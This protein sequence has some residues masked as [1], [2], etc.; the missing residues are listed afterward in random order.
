MLEISSSSS[1]FQ[2]C[3]HSLFQSYVYTYI[4]VDSWPLE[5]SSINPN[6][7][8]SLHAIKAKSIFQRVYITH[9]RYPYV[10]K[11]L[12][13]A[14]TLCLLRPRLH[15]AESETS[16]SL[17]HQLI[18][19]ILLLQFSSILSLSTS[20]FHARSHEKNLMSRKY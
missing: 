17:L 1:N 6:F 4:L 16:R 8:R 3:L 13:L 9:Q 15:R 19:I 2:H 10:K 7:D 20:L 18:S 14:T 5:T 12:I 11:M